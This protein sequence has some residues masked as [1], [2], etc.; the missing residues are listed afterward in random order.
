MPPGYLEP[1]ECAGSRWD[2]TARW[3]T[4]PSNHEGAGP[5]AGAT[6]RLPG[7]SV[8]PI[9]LFGD[10][11]LRTPA[12]PVVD[13]DGELRRLLLSGGDDPVTLHP[14]HA[15]LVD[16]EQVGG[17]DDATVVPLALLLIHVNT[18]GGTIDNRAT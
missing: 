6:P 15:Q 11:V 2:P 16:L 9:R 12:A 8:T 5:L 4:S 17:E 14:V 13:F 3:S 10:P 1:G 18:H 7:V